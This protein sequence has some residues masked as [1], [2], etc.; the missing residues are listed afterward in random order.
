MSV[1]GWRVHDWIS[2]A[3]F[4]S[5]LSL[6][7][8]SEVY[9]FNCSTNIYFNM[10]LKKCNIQSSHMIGRFYVRDVNVVSDVKAV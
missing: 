10:G 6:I 7:V 5:S 8:D 4:Y 1:K 2:L 9:H 3:Q